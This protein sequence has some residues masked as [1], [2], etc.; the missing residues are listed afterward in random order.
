MDLYDKPTNTQRCLPFTSSHPNHFKWNIPFCL[1]QRIYTIA[2][3]NSE[4]LKNLENLKTNLPKYHYP[5]SLIKQ[6]FQKALSIPQKDLLKPKKSSNENILP[7]ITTFNPNN[8]NIYSTIKSI[9]W[10]LIAW[11]II[12]LAVFI[13]SN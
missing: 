12:T 11:K 10:R 2:G 5:N 6:G 9:A 7:L 4:K 1:A 8:P 3:N 13:I